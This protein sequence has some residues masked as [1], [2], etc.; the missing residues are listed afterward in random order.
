[1]TTI[2]TKNLH[3]LV[4]VMMIIFTASCKDDIDHSIITIDQ[5]PGRSTEFLEKYFPDNNIISAN[6][7]DNN[8]AY[9]G[10]FLASLDEN[11]EIYF[12]NEGGWLDIAT[13]NGL[14]ETGKEIIF[15]KLP[16]YV[17]IKEE[18]NGHYSNGKI[19]N[20]HN[21]RDGQI[22]FV[23]D[24]KEVSYIIEGHEGWTYADKYS[25]GRYEIPDKIKEFFKSNLK[26]TTRDMPAPSPFVLRFSGHKGYIYRYEGSN[27]TII[28]FYE[29]GE[30]FYIK[31]KDDKNIDIDYINNTI[32]E[33]I[34]TSLIENTEDAKDNITAITRYNNSSL[35]GFQYNKGYF[36][37]IDKDG[38]IIDAPS[39]KAE[40]YITNHFPSNKYDKFYF[41][42]N[43]GGAYYLRYSLRAW[44][45]DKEVRLQTDYQGNMRRISAGP[46]TTTGI[47]IVP[48]PNS[49]LETMPKAALE[50]VT[51]NHPD[52]PIIQIDYNFSKGNDDVS[53]EFSFTLHIPNN[54]KFIYFNSVTG[55]YIKEY[56]AMN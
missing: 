8:D 12:D 16:N 23:L 38:Q 30:W 48:I 11:I 27:R 45:P 42:I 14:S 10:L 53:E 35:Y 7:Y 37:V 3:Y 34:Y 31:Q 55:E 5:L 4:I 18:F 2:S 1:M 41:H 51:E 9:G 49:I 33:Y 47:G 36:T 54:L 43:T 50:Y 17:G 15:D 26:S 39:S 46:I 28:D 40:E 20:M 29:N 24:N 56:N 22:E 52:S 13:P 21:N 6:K 32:P 25:E 19:I 44:S